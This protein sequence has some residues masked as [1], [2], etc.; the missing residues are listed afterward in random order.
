MAQVKL[1]QQQVSFLKNMELHTIIIDLD[2][3]QGSKGTI[4]YH[5]GGDLQYCVET[6]FNND[7]LLQFAKNAETVLKKTFDTTKG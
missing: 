2:Q 3:H 5:I 7:E 6:N 1:I 4:S